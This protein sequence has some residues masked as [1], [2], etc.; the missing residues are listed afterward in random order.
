M[1]DNFIVMDDFNNGVDLPS[2]KHDN[3][4]ELI[5]QILI[6]PNTCFVKTHTSKTE[7]ILTNNLN[8]FRN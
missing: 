8:F 2:C 4:E 6:K 7:L 3:L 5:G 1:C